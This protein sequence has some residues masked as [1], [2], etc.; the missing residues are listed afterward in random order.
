V[1]NRTIRKIF[2]ENKLNTTPSTQQ[3]N[4]G[5]K[6]WMDWERM[7]HWEIDRSH[8][9]NKSR[10]IIDS[11]PAKENQSAP[12]DLHYSGGRTGQKQRRKRKAPSDLDGPVGI[13]CCFLFF[14]GEGG[15]LLNCDEKVFGR[16]QQKSAEEK[17]AF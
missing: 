16:N 14:V 9:R 11:S 2:L 12:T 8:E 15:G 3:T 10:Q 6:T 4:L 7:E 5:Q 1:F 17:A 13:L